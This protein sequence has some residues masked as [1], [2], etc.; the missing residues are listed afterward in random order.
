MAQCLVGG[1]SSGNGALFQFQ[2]ML[3][4]LVQAR[5]DFFFFWPTESAGSVCKLIRTL[6]YQH[7][8]IHQALERGFFR[9]Q[10]FII[11][12]HKCALSAM[13]N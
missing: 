2:A 10:V 6:H 9:N 13:A 7:K 4:Q 12:L 5:T 3:F 1:L 11:K 8:V